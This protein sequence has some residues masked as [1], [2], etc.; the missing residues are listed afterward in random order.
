MHF[1][2]LANTG[3]TRTRTIARISRRRR[4]GLHAGKA[5]HTHDHAKQ[6]GRNRNITTVS[7]FH[8]STPKHG[9]TETCHLRAMSE[10]VHIICT[11]P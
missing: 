10:S 7:M 2:T 1:F 3:S 11:M 6:L 9:F 4:S 8:T 5:P